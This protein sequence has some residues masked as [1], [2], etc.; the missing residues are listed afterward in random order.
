ML[1]A[2]GEQSSKA[3]QSEGS[4]QASGQEESRYVCCLPVACAQSFCTLATGRSD[5]TQSALSADDKLPTL[6]YKD[7]GAL[8]ELGKMYQQTGS[9]TLVQVQQLVLVP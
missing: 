7:A 8:K 1:H 6:Y 2:G 3:H 4:T 5:P 9:G